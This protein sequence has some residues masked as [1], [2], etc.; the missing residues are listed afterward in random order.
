MGDLEPMTKD[1]YGEYCNARFWPEPH[2]LACVLAPGHEG[3]HASSLPDPVLVPARDPLDAPF[4]DIDANE[5]FR[6]L[7]WAGSRPGVLRLLRALRDANY[8]ETGTEYLRRVAVNR[9]KCGEANRDGETC[10]LPAG[11]SGRH[12]IGESWW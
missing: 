11:H 1:G 10:T 4:P 2:E 8:D 7:Q 3:E 6:L 5:R 9:L 12:F